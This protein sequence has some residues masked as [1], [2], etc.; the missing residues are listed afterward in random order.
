MRVID[1]FDEPVRTLTVSPDGRFLAATSRDELTL[2]DWISGEE[3]SRHSLPGG[4]SQLAF[5]SDSAWLARVCLPGVF[6]LIDPRNGQRIHGFPGLYSGGVAVSPNGKTLAATRA[7]RLKLVPLELWELPTRHKKTP[8]DF[9]SPFTRLAYSQDGDLLAG[10]GR[11][12]F[13]VRVASTGGWI[14][15]HQVSYVGEGYFSFPRQG[16]T[17]VFGGE[18]YLHIMDTCTGN[19]LPRRLTLPENRR[20]LD[21]A[22]LGNGRQFATVDGTP[23]LRVW[24]AESWQIVR[25]YDWNAGGLTCVIPS[26]DGLAGICGTQTGKLV[27]FDVDD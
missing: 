13:E 4:V 17:V 3:L 18:P 27:V 25:G 5:G 20:F 22:F 23:L 19:I 15:G 26:A 1:A 12:L 10:I 21:I 6:E 8:Y 2:W 11:N 7:G 9:W 24:S 14:G 16:L